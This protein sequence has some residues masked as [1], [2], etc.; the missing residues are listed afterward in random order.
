VFSY[1]SNT[2]DAVGRVSHSRV[3]FDMAA[4]TASSW[5]LATTASRW[6][7]AA[8]TSSQPSRPEFH[9]SSSTFG[10]EILA[11]VVG[12]F[13]WRASP[14]VVNASVDDTD[15]AMTFFA[16]DSKIYSCLSIL[17]FVI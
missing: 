4:T 1:G 5:I 3:D 10:P 6:I 9:H 2:Y 15:V 12:T 14:A 13:S 7:L 8:T 11:A 17:T 16:T